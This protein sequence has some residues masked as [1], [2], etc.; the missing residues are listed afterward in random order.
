MKLKAMKG[1]MKH[2]SFWQG[3]DAQIQMN[4]VWEGEFGHTYPGG[5]TV[6]DLCQRR[7]GK[8]VNKKK[9]D[10]G[11]ANPWIAAVVAARKHGA[12]GEL[13]NGSRL[14]TKARALYKQFKAMDLYKIKK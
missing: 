6:D 8:I 9:S 14:H 10:K 5:Y 12:T 11:K 13:K 3:S 2:H 7:D 1:V 4:L